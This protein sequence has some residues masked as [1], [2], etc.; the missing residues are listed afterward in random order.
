MRR[1]SAVCVRIR[2]D[3]SSSQVVGLGGSGLSGP[4]EAGEEGSRTGLVITDAGKALSVRRVQRANRSVRNF[5]ENVQ[6]SRT[7]IA[8]S[9]GKSQTSSS[10]SRGHDFAI[11][12]IEGSVRPTRP[13][14]CSHSRGNDL[15]V[16]SRT[17]TSVTWVRPERSTPLRLGAVEASPTIV[18]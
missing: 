6:I 1:L 16:S 7:E 2:G 5:L 9:N 15:A 12:E 3:R 18:L 13:F 10:V 4:Q 11:A 14:R 8:V 17:A